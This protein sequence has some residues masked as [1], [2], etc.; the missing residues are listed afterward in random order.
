VW[1]AASGRGA[2]GSLPR[3]RVSSCPRPP[4]PF[5]AAAAASA[6]RGFDKFDVQDKALDR[7][8]SFATRHDVHL[9]LVIHPRKEAEDEPL[10]LSSVFGSAKA[11]QVRRR[12]WLSFDRR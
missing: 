2:A 5:E 7:F 9:T 4:C 11:T 12:R 6:G 1:W 8:R 10:S 3:V